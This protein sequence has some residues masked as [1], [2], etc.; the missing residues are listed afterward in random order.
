MKL[1][2]VRHGESVGNVAGIHQSGQT[3]LSEH[4]TRQAKIV[5]E[6]FKKIPVDVIISSDY[7]RAAKTAEMISRTVNKT[8]EHTPLLR[9]LKRPTILEGKHMHDPSIQKTKKALEENSHVLDWHHSDEE[10]PFDFKK[11]VIEF[12]K[13]ISARKE[14]NI[15]VVTHG[16]FLR[17]LTAVLMLGEDADIDQYYKIIN[18]FKLQNT[19]IT[20][21]EKRD[22]WRLI[23]WND[24]A[25]LG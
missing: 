12:I 20:V 16:M 11:R 14:H 1:Y 10:N 6:R 15:A 23:T 19:G 5:A 17:M 2:I 22:E 18:I 21:W 7:I 25:H 3:Q 8:V 4:G 9:E 13:F 24:H